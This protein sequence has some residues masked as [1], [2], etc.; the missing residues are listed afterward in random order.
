MMLVE[1]AG[2]TETGVRESNQDSYRAVSYDGVFAVA[3]GMGGLQH[4]DRISKAAIERVE[5][6]AD[7]FARL[8]VDGA[9]SQSIENRRAL[10]DT[11]EEFFHDTA[12]ELYKMAD[13]MGLRMGTT[14]SV[15]VL[16]GDRMTI[17]HVG[18]TRVYRVRG[19]VAEQL[20]EDHSVAA[21]RLRRG[22]ISY[23]E[24][25]ESPQLGL[26]YQSLGPVP[27]IDPHVVEA[28]ISRG[29]TVVLASDGVWGVLEPT[30]IARIVG[31][32]SAEECARALVQQALDNGSD[33]NC[34]AIVVRILD[35]GKTPS[36]P[37]P[38]AL[39]EARLFKGME[40]ADLRA[41]VPYTV[42]RE[43]PEGTLVFREGEPAEEL[44]IIEDG[45]IEIT[46]QGVPLAQLG[47][48]DHLG[49]LAIATEGTRT[50]SARAVFD[51]RLLILS[52]S[53]LDEITERK[54][55]LAIRL[56]KRLLDNTSRRLIDFT[57]RISM[58]E[59]SLYTPLE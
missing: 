20:T 30:D 17:G 49:E 56:Y 48:G 39:G 52:R 27:E 59:R 4:G 8:A 16:F 21:S 25:R 36:A 51:A 38:T 41:L 1:A 47:P 15:A 11:M 26:L 33:D 22:V 14:L 7:H 34:T 3:D 19:N 53:A 31:G 43:V 45:A 35:I 44:L 23:G 9:D 28:E 55:D 42:Y 5:S 50:A 57:S 18:D 37:L 13:E 54:P 10:F 6:S 2:H 40:E 46:R 12:T 32:G 58:A 24:Y 29:D